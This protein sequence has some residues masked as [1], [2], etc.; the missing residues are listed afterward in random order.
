MGGVSLPLMAGP[1]SDEV[2]SGADGDLEG[3]G[4]KLWVEGVRAWVFDGVEVEGRRGAMDRV[5][6]VELA[7]V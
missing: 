3:G 1:R 5:C 2:L 4:G 6:G 7:R